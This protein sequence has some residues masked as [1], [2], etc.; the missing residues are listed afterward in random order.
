MKFTTFA[1]AALF[2]TY[3]SAK[4]PSWRAASAV[5]PFDDDFKVPGDNPLKHCA[6]PS[7]DILDITSVDISPNPPKPGEVLSIKASGNVSKEVTEGAYVKLAVKYGL[8]TLLRQTADLCSSAE[9]VDLKCPIEKGELTLTKEVKLPG[10]IPPGK[11][12]VTADVYSDDDEQIT[13]LTAVVEFKRDGSSSFL[14]GLVKQE[15]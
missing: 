5:T 9:E 15:V 2:A 7:E 14:S 10:T 6:D 3:A 4:S 12:T 11:Y 8:I 1:S 13:C